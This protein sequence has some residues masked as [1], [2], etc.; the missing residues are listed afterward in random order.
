MTK[1][2]SKKEI[3]STLNRVK[4]RTCQ[5]LLVTCLH[6]FDRRIFL[7]FFLNALKTW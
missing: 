4:L 6:S 7:D 5:I 3:Y 2:S 1:L